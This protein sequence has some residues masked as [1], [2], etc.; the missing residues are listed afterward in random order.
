VPSR[1]GGFDVLGPAAAQGSPDL[2]ALARVLQAVAAREP[3]PLEVTPGG[4]RAVWRVSD[5]LDPGTDPDTLG[6]LNAAAIGAD[7]EFNF[8]RFNDPNAGH[9]G[10]AGVSQTRVLP[11]LRA[12][13]RLRL[14]ASR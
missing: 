1:G 8:P 12:L 7:Q 2:A 6:I 13:P 4:Q 11:T 10:T 3:A 9:P 5:N 14:P